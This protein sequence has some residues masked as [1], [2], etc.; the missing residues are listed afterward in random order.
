[1]NLHVAVAIAAVCLQGASTAVMYFLARAPGWQRVRLKA[2]IAFTAGVYSAFDLW[3]YLHPDDLELRATL[4][5]LNTVVAAVHMLMWTRFTFSDESGAWRSMPRWSLLAAGGVVAAVA[6]AAALDTMLDRS[7]LVVVSVPRLH[8]TERIY[9]FNEV[10]NGLA[11]LVLAV[12]LVSVV[13]H[14]RRGQRG[15]R[16]ARW[17]ALGLVLYLLC[18]IEEALVASGLVPFMYLA[19]VGYL[20]ASL[21]LTMQLMQRFGDDA[22]RLADLSAQLSSEVAV[23]TV[24]RDAARESLAE[25]QRLAALGRL[26]AGV[27]HEINNPLQYLQL[28]LEELRETLGDRGSAEIDA[29]LADALD[30]A[31]RIGGVVTSLRS[32]GV[33]G[34][35]FR[36]VDLHAAIEAGLRIASP[37]LRPDIVITRTLGRVPLVLGDEGQLVQI[38]VNPVLNAAQALR[39]SSPSGHR[40]ITVASRTTEQGEAELVISDNGPGF[41]AELLPRL[42]EPFLTTRAYAGGSGLGLFVTRGLVAAHGGTLTFENAADGGARVIIRIPAAPPDALLVAPDASWPVAAPHPLRI[43]IV[44]DE[45][46]LCAALQRQLTRLG[47]HPQIAVDGY[48]ALEII[49]HDPIDVVISDLMM[50]NL[51]GASFADLL[52]ERNPTL[53]ARL[54]IMT[55]GAVTAE[56]ETFLARDDLLV[57]NKPVSINELTR[58]LAEVTT[59]PT[60]SP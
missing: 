43:L 44:D 28:R 23:R 20:F 27:G 42:G 16:S 40:H 32:Y 47:H 7:R 50:P 35:P 30:G 49:A 58:A 48:E 17:I 24:E 1:M 60:R 5:Q 9:A 2:A 38:V 53:R 11:V 36:P 54:I 56:D 57:L 4:V 19:S 14:V 45:P 8:I 46:A 37:Q 59:R 25:Q 13:Q 6:T 21:P 55:G 22:R 12:L 26:A 33:R 31:H 29:A 10:G 34:E 18:I 51:S 3:F 41:A 15:D 39:Q 52:A